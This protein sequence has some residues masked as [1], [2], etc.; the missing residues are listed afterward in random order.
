MT[1]ASFP[2]QPGHQVAARRLLAAP[3]GLAVE[4]GSKGMVIAVMAEGRCTVRFHNGCVVAG[5][6]GLDI[7][8]VETNLR[9]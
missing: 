1:V 5:L 7:V 8:V 2:W 6:D 3:G 9:C 4:A